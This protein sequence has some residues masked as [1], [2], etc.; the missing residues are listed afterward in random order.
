MRK[1][2]RGTIK[3][4]Q[5]LCKLQQLRKTRREFSRIFSI[6]KNFQRLSSLTLHWN[7]EKLVKIFNASSA[8]TNGIAERALRRVKE[9]T[10][11]V[12]LTSGLEEQWRA[13]SMNMSL[14]FTQCP[15]SL[16]RGRKLHVK[17]RFTEPFS[18]PIIPFDAKVEYHPTSTKDQARLHQF[19][20]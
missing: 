19:G 1:E 3:G 5:L 9:G 17:R 13:E 15:R 6:L 20:N 4:T 10:S 18:G 12:L 7:L 16:T 11:S 14:L 2:N 8:R